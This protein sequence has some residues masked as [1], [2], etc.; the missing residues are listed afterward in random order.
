MEMKSISSKAIID[1]DEWLGNMILF[2]SMT[3]LVKLLLCEV[4]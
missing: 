1:N 4:I 2:V 3:T